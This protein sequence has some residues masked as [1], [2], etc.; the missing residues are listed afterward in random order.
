[1][2]LFDNGVSANGAGVWDA[3]ENPAE[4]FRWDNP[5]MYRGGDVSEN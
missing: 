5:D 2:Q 4:I 3:I 1:M